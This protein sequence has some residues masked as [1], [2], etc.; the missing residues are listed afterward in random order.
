MMKVFE[1]YKDCSFDNFKSNVDVEILKNPKALKNNIILI[2]GV[3]TGKTHLAYAILNMLCEKKE[4][5]SGYRYYSSDFVHYASCKEIIDNIKKC[6]DKGADEYDFNVIKTYKEIPLL[7]IDE[8]GVQYG[9]D[10]ERIEL[11][12][13]INERYNNCYPTIA[14]SNYSKQ[15]IVKTL[16]LRITDRLFGGAVIIELNGNSYR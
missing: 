7:I 15:Q 3:G 13:I 16:G 8:V 1:R 14:I 2:G 12:E 9:T 11:F 5:S 10:S 4:L 6:W